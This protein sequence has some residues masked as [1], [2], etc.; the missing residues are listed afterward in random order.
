MAYSDY[1]FPQRF[2]SLTDD[3][4]QPDIIELLTWNDFG[5]SHYIRDLPSRNEAAKDYVELGELGNYVWGQNHAPWRVMA[6]YYISWWKNGHPPAIAEDQV[7]YWHRIH[8]KSAVCAGGS[9]EPIRNH[10]FPEDAV[11]VWAL[12]KEPATI[13]MSI[14]SNRDWTFEAD[15]Q[16]PSMGSVPFPWDIPQDGV[17]PQVRIMRKGRTVQVGISSQP[18]KTSCSWENF[19][20]PAPTRCSV[21]ETEADLYSALFRSCCQL[22]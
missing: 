7:M 11:F 8:P 13:S 22:R 15:S 3:A 21:S 4:I 12:V 14:G 18:V 6:K 19:S 16:G 1:L 9:S 10:Q 2:T 17:R 20:K 5:E